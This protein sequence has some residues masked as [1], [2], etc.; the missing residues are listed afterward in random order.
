MMGIFAS[1]K[2]A[3]FGKD[4]VDAKPAVAAP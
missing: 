3:V 2:N 4:E 1:I